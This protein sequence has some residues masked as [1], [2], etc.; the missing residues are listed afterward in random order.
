M[1]R[2][3]SIQRLTPAAAALFG[4]FAL[5]GCGMSDLVGTSLHPVSLSFIAGSA[6]VASRGSL[7]V[8]RDI[9]IGP[10]GELVLKKIQL[11]LVR[12]E[13]S[14]SAA[15]GCANDDSESGD[16]AEGNDGLEGSDNSDANKNSQSGD[17]CEELSADPVL[18]N[19]P[20][21]DAVHTVITV[22]LAAGTYGRLHAKLSPIAAT[23]VASLGAPSDMTGKS[24]RVEGTFKGVPFVY[25]APIK[26][27]LDLAFNPPLVIDGTTKNATVKIDVTKWF[28]GTGGN[29]VDPT[30]ANAGG[31]NAKLV[32]AN[33]RSSFK[34]FEDDDRHG[35]DDHAN[36]TGNH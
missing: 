14:P 10:T 33:I 3:F 31:A 9:A 26:A 13:L 30:T 18:A 20:V 23:T 17:D 22:P 1:N 16:D 24:V 36:E 32:S 12:I 6:G 34:A 7:G 5:G 8:S 29:V 2:I 35:D 27:D 15:G 19:I 21:D 11:A 28:I 4:A 25:T